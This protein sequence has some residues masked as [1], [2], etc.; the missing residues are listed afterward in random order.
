[1]KIWIIR[2]YQWIFNT[3]QGVCTALETRKKNLLQLRCQHMLCFFITLPASLMDGG[4][5]YQIMSMYV[6]ASALLCCARAL[7]LPVLLNPLMSQ[8]LF[9]S[10]C[11][12]LK[13]FCFQNITSHAVSPCTWRCGDNRRVS[14]TPSLYSIY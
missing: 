8:Q 7:P 13:A 1:M 14:C 3:L 11:F 6:Y 10:K 12:G 5:S 9:R 4:N 2:V